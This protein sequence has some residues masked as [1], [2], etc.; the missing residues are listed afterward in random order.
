MLIN[1]SFRTSGLYSS[2]HK[3]QIRNLKGNNNISAAHNL[4]CYP[5]EYYI[6]NFNLPAAFGRKLS[7]KETIQKI[8]RGNFPS[9]E[10]ADRYEA[11][12]NEP[13][14]CVHKEYYSG[15]LDCSTLEEAKQKYPEFINV[16]NVSEIDKNIF[17]RSIILKKIKSG[18]IYGLTIENLPLELL[19]RQ[20][21]EI[22]SI[23][24]KNN[25]FGLTKDTVIRLFE[26]LKIPRL[27]RTYYYVLSG[28]KP[29]FAEK[30]SSIMKN[31]WDAEQGEKY[32]KAKALAWE[33]HP[34]IKQVMVECAK[35]FP[36]LKSSLQKI[37]AGRAGQYEYMIK[38]AYL[39]ACEDKMPGYQKIIGR[40]YHDILSSLKS[41]E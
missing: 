24:D 25:Y 39:K 37:K 31:N 22:K 18:A 1:H 36:S 19:K 12:C 27:N 3:I 32:R 2:A 41:E 8:G 23:K 35:E 7:P 16:I 15:L 21:A 40:E 6:S 14:Y 30:I 4:E 9:E 13:L 29:E 17:D 38:N 26:I 10:L 20:Y 28:S 33:R 5:I 11:S 34:E